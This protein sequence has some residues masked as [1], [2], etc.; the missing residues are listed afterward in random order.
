MS[1]RDR[2][3]KVKVR[4]VHIEYQISVEIIF[5]TTSKFRNQHDKDDLVLETPCFTSGQLWSGFEM[6]KKACKDE[7]HIF[8][9]IVLYIS[10]QFAFLLTFLTLNFA[11]RQVFEKSCLG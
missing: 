2:L 11:D 6:I 7:Y 1:L 8:S 3:S 4:K 10:R 9:V 5:C